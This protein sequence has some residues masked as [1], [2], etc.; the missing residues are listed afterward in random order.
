M[1]IVVTGAT[2]TVGSKVIEELS[3]KDVKIRALVRDEA[4]ARRFG[5]TNVE[6]VK[7][8]LANERGLETAFAGADKLFLASGSAQN[9][10]ELQGN[11]VVAAKRAGIK[12]IVKLSVLGA[13]AT[14]PVKLARWHFQSDEEIRRSGIAY[15]ILQ[16]TFFIDNLLG[17][18]DTIKKDGAFYAPMKN[19]RAS[20][21]DARD[22]A[23]V[24]VTAL[25]ERGHEGKTYEIT[26]PEAVSYTDIAETLG[27]E[28][29][30]KVTYVDVPPETAK[31]TML[32]MGMPDW[33][34]EDML[35]L[36]E[37]FASGGGEKVAPTV[38]KLTGHQG[39]TVD[40]FVKDHVSAYK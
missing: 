2:G 1:L 4:K 27:K 6:I 28:L 33:Y 21:V 39:H 25:T 36:S 38:E 5:W 32:Q 22:I 37:F 10:A 12:Q 18:A 8:D 9:Q 20:M 26:G 30:R 29:G 11:A 34:V 3:R 17:Y 14:S 40:E 31:K 19:G 23:A 15:T 24:A 35:K 13:S 16:P 7:G